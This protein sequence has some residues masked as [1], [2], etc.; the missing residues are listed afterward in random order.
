VRV[1]QVLFN[2]WPLEG[3]ANFIIIDCPVY[4]NE[5]NIGFLRTASSGIDVPVFVIPEGF[6][7]GYGLAR[8]LSADRD[9]LP[10]I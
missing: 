5:K 1:P 8:L 7:R 3:A 9:A 2:L 4:K 6:H 10:E